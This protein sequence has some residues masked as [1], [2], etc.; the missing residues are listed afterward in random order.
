MVTVKM[1]GTFRLD[2]GIK[3]LQLEA[4][5]VKDLYPQ[6]METVLEAN[7][8]TTLTMKDVKGCIVCLHDKQVRPSTKLNDGDEVVLVPAVAGG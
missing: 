5:R 6:I 2:S 8:D 3:E 4:K 1:F 7:P